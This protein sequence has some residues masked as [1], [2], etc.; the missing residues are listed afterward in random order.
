MVLKKVDFV[1]VVG[2][3]VWYSVTRSWESRVVSKNGNRLLM[4]KRIDMCLILITGLWNILN[5]VKLKRI[6]INRK[7]FTQ[8]FDDSCHHFQVERIK[9]ITWYLP[10]KVIKRTDVKVYMLMVTQYA[11]NYS[12]KFLTFI[13]YHLAWY[14]LSYQFYSLFTWKWWHGVIETLCKSSFAYFYP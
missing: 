11:Q 13:L 3:S 1:M 12:F 8:R 5:L 6:K 4:R 14:I 2:C 7:K 10:C 9:L